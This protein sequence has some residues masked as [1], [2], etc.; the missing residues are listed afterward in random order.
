MFA[1]RATRSGKEYA[2]YFY[3]KQRQRRSRIPSVDFNQFD[4][5]YNNYVNE[6]AYEPEESKEDTASADFPPTPPRPARVRNH[7]RTAPPDMG[8]FPYGHSRNLVFHHGHT[9]P[10]N[11]YTSKDECH[12]HR[13]KDDSPY[14]ENVNAYKRRVAK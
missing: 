10:I 1:R 4:N 13:K 8:M 3:R 14:T 2:G 7:V 12:R 9:H 5:F 6:N 11:M